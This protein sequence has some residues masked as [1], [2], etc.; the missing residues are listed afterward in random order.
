MKTKVV[1]YVR[2]STDEQANE[3]V[4]LDAQRGKLAQ[5][6]DLH[7]LD[8]VATEADAGVSAKT[9]DRPGLR[10]ALYRL[11]SGE[12]AGLLIAKLDRLS[13]SV[14][15]WNRLIEAYFGPVAGKELFSVADSIDTRTA[16]GRMVLNILMSVAQWERE[17]IAERTRTRS[18][19][20]VRRANA[21][22]K[23][24]TASD[25]TRTDAPSMPTTPNARRSPSSGGRGPNARRSGR[26]P[27]P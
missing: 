26:S 1:G 8:L 5:Y 3:G 13:R 18:R 17:A 14:S 16:A 15:D 20:N 19:T 11:A 7:D 9:L 22:A 24:H 25:W 23:S 21:S 2:V 12:A 6:A 27:R 10:V 4:S